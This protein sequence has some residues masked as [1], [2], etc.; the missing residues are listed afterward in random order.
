MKSISTCYEENLARQKSLGVTPRG[1]IKTERRVSLTSKARVRF[2]V[3]V[4]FFVFFNCLDSHH[5]HIFS[6]M[7]NLFLY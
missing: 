1:S 7:I 4:F 6:H 3:V 5:T 2:G